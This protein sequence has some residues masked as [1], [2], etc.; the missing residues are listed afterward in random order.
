M[1]KVVIDG[2]E[3]SLTHPVEIP[4][5]WVGQEELVTQLLAAWLVLGENDRHLRTY[6]CAGGAVSLTVLREVN[7]EPVRLVHAEYVEQT[8][9][10]TL[11]AVATTIMV[12]NREPRCPRP[13]FSHPCFLPE[14]LQ[15][16]QHTFHIEAGRV[17]EVRTCLVVRD[18][19]LRRSVSIDVPENRLD[20]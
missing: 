19:N 15:S 17:N 18:R 16:R 8:E 14:I 3:L 12:D 10:K 11:M 7:L 2:I 20:R 9:A 6:S 1:E 13:R 5:D 4:M